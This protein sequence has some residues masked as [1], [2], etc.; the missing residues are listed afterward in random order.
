MKLVRNLPAR[1]NKSGNSISWAVFWCDGCE[2]EVEKQLSHGKRDKSC[3]CKQYLENKANFKHGMEGT[4]IYVK[5]KN[6][7]KR[8]LNSENK[9]YSDYGGRGI[10]ICNEWLEFIPF[11]DWALNNGYA[12]N[13]EIDRINTN[14]NYEPNNCRFITHKE[15]IRNRR[16]NAIKNKEV[17]DEIIGLGKTEKYTRKELAEKFNVSISIINQIINNKIWMD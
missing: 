11:R 14:G 6:M 1:K 17:A 13:L 4:K 9:D 5:W 15:N 10:I 3:G 2:Q 16:N 7:K 8:C 12:D